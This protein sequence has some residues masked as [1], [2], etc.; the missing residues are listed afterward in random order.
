MNKNITIIGTVT[1]DYDVNQS[2]S[3]KEIMDNINL[4]NVNG[5]GFNM[6]NILVKIGR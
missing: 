2:Y 1:K 5:S 4:M 6:L 3:I